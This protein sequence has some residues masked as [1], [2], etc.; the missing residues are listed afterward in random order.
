MSVFFGLPKLMWQPYSHYFFHFNV[1]ARMSIQYSYQCYF[2]LMLDAVWW[3]TWKTYHVPLSS[4][5]LSAW[6]W[7]SVETPEKS[8]FNKTESSSSILWYTYFCLYQSLSCLNLRS[9]QNTSAS[10]I[11]ALCQLLDIQ[12]RQ[13]TTLYLDNVQSCHV[14]HTSIVMLP[15]HVPW[16]YYSLH[17]IWRNSNFHWFTS[18]CWRL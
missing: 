3:V 18:D 12:W 10:W 6:S 9:R 13:Q 15:A 4:P 7:H 11:S 1:T 16:M 2:P 5:V 8:W 17:K 14:K